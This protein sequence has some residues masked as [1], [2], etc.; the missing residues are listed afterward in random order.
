MN[1]QLYHFILHGRAGFYATEEEGIKIIN[2]INRR[3]VEMDK[4]PHTYSKHP[5]TPATLETFFDEWDSRHNYVDLCLFPGNCY[6]V[7]RSD[8]SVCITNF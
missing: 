3:R 1:A 4:E 7:Y 2:E 6:D 8:S 5:I